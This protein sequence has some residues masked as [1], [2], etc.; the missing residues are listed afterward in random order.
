[1]SVL[2]E[3]K[4]APR[5]Y[6]WRR[7]TGTG[8]YIARP[9]SSLM[10]S[11]Q[12][13]AGYSGKP[14]HCSGTASVITKATRVSAEGLLRWPWVH[15]SALLL[16]LL[17]WSGLSEHEQSAPDSFPAR[18]VR[19]SNLGKGPWAI[20][21]F[22]FQSQPWDGCQPAWCF[23]TAEGRTHTRYVHSTQK[24]VFKKRSSPSS[25]N[26]RERWE[27]LPQLWRTVYTRSSLTATKG[28]VKWFGA[29][30]EAVV[31]CVLEHLLMSFTLSFAFPC[32]PFH[33]TLSLQHTHQHWSLP[34]SPTQ[35]V[36]GSIYIPLNTV[37]VFKT[38]T[39]GMSH[40]GSGLCF[41]LIFRTCFSIDEQVFF[42]FLAKL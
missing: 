4:W 17:P 3:I 42:F 13:L 10:I 20:L 39:W 26:Y 9:H 30:K 29:D 5:G 33:T 19:H 27:G 31:K 32:L 40:K 41:L 6:R 18:P 35:P 25:E 15:T 37:A 7:E 21:R 2:G 22:P 23:L 1:M 14:P 36:S 16:C 12:L 24:K 11:W 34:E 38:A 8:S 28:R